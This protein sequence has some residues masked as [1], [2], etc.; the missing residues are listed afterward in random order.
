MITRLDLFTRHWFPKRGTK[1][2]SKWLRYMW[3][4]EI[5][6]IQKDIVSLSDWILLK[7]EDDNNKTLFAHVRTYYRPGK[8][9]QP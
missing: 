8:H 2:G 1:I 5:N 3:I 4:Y 7:Y 9:Y 6:T